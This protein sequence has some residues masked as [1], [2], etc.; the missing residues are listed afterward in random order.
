MGDD[1]LYCYFSKKQA[2]V[3]SAA[4]IL[5][6]MT[7]V[8]RAISATEG[9]GTSLALRFCSSTSSRSAP[10]K[11]SKQVNRRTRNENPKKSSRITMIV[12]ISYQ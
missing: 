4:R 1:N 11:L 2:N 6:A 10:Q 3:A 9:V 7:L 12:M 5:C 8:V